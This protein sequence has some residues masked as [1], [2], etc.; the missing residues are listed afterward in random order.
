MKGI[1]SKQFFKRSVI[2]NKK[3]FYGTLGVDKSAT[4]AD[5]KKA[6]ISAFDIIS[7]PLLDPP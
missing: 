5:I 1:S 4:Q 6:Y 7:L 2:L 3:D